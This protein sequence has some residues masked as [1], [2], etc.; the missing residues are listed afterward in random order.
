MQKTWSQKPKDVQKAKK[1][2]DA[3]GQ[4]LGRLASVVAK[5]LSGRYKPEFTPHVPQ[6]DLVVI[7][8]SDQ[9]V[10]TG[11]KWTNK[12]YYTKSH[13]VGSLKERS[14]KDLPKEE[15]IK[16]AVQGMLPKN[17]HRKIFLKNLK[18]FK[19]SNHTYKDQDLE[20]YKV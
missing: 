16:R 7:V 8:N 3:S 17:N 5:L 20:T 2:V 11:K 6:G 12:K 9:V 10:L 4:S 13:Y 18:V 19:D 14:A 15:L 1:L